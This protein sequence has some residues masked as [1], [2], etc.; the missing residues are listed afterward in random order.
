MMREFDA[1]YRGARNALVDRFDEASIVRL[2]T[3]RRKKYEALWRELPYIGGGK[4]ADTINLIMGA[5]TL[6]FVLVLTNEEISE[7]QIG[8]VIYDSFYG[9]FNSRPVF[10]RRILGYIAGTQVFKRRMTRQIE[11]SSLRRYRDDFVSERVEPLSLQ[12]DFGYNYVECAIHKLFVKYDAEEFLKYVCLG[13][14][15]MFRSL[16]IGFTRTQTIAN[17]ALYCDFRFKK[18]GETASGWPP[19]QLPE[20][21]G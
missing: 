8:R 17:G 7:R 12:Y 6:S 9:Y 19:E 5:I 21:R 16:G 14:F 20:W 10:L 4:N 15:A 18:N 3:L 1:M 13:D 2:S 11:T